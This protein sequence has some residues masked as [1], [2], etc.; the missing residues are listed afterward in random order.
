MLW[1]LFVRGSY[2]YSTR[3][4]KLRAF[5]MA[6]GEYTLAMNSVSIDRT[7]DTV[8]AIRCYFLR[9]SVTNV[10]PQMV[11]FEIQPFNGE[12]DIGSL[13][14]FPASFYD[15]KYPDARS[16]LES[17]GM[18]WHKYTRQMP[19]HMQYSGTSWRIVQLKTEAE[20]DRRR[21]PPPPLGDP[22]LP[23]LP[24]SVCET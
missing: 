21:L 7:R 1:L 13:S 19:L 17:R 4:G 15:A 12:V 2:I 5:V 23:K 6:D 22:N 9:Y 20:Q 8:F 14:V 3:S 18:M 11:T 16:E 24:N 10:V